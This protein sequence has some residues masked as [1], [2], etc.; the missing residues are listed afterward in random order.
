MK[1]STGEALATAKFDETVE[2]AI[3]LG[4]D[5]RSPS[6]CAWHA[7]TA[8]G[9]GQTNRVAVFAAGEAEQAARD[10]GA[11]ESGRRGPGGQGR[12]WNP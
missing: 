6:R 4:I 9:H 7:V 11:D 3:R 8:C 1:P 2:L 5:P 10:A 12:R